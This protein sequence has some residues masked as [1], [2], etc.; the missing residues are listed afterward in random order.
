MKTDQPLWTN[1][2]LL[3]PDEPKRLPRKLKKYLKKGLKK[4]GI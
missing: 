1:F 2:A 3:I 4:M